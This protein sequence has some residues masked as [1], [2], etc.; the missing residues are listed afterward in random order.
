VG[1]AA[2]PPGSRP[3]GGTIRTRY[4]HGQNIFT[5]SKIKL[6]D[7]P[8]DD[9]PYAGWLYGSIGL[10]AETGQRLDVLD[11][12]LGIVGPASLAE[13]TQRS[14]RHNGFDTTDPPRAGSRKF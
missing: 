13:E 12:T 6:E 5:P 10:I 9:R 4:A 3:D 11:L 1:R 7:P 8:P 14:S 2:P